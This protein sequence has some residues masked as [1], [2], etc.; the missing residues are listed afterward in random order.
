MSA[1]LGRAGI[2]PR[3]AAPV[4]A[5][6]AA[7]LA[8][9]ALAAPAALAV[10]KTLTLTVA[11]NAKVSDMGQA[12]TLKNIAVNSGGFAVYTLSGETPQ[13]VKCTRA[14]GCLSFW[15]PVTASSKKSLSKPKSIKGKLGLWHRGAI[16]Q[17][18]LNNHPLYTFKLDTSKRQAQG[19][20]VKSFGGT[21]HVTTAQGSSNSG[22]SS[23]PMSPSPSPYPTSG[24]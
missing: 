3:R 1:E 22:G 24:Y 20:N 4:L 2:R 14:S 12:T 18:T 17:V 23:P 21:W 7:C 6:V 13:H 9:A 8:A 16:K 10:A 15:F 5:T 11:N 19:Q